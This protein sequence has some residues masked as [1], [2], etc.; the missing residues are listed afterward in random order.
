MARIPT[1]ESQQTRV[2]PKQEFHTDTT[3][4]VV[5][6]S[7]GQGIQ[8]GTQLAGAVENY[9][10]S[11]AEYD[12]QMNEAPRMEAI[13]GGQEKLNVENNKIRA[14]MAKAPNPQRANDLL[15]QKYKELI[16]NPPQDLDD[17][18]L[19]EWQKYMMAEKYRLR[20]NNISWGEKAAKIAGEQA[21]KKANANAFDRMSDDA[22]R[23][24]MERRPFN[25][26]TLDI[27][28]TGRKTDRHIPAVN[29]GD[30]GIQDALTAQHFM[31][32]AEVPLETDPTDQ[33]IKGI[34]G[35]SL[36]DVGATTEGLL[37]DKKAK[38]KQE[39]GNEQI[40]QYFDNLRSAIDDS[41]L[42]D[43]EK[44]VLTDY[45]DAKQKEKRRQFNDYI[46]ATNLETQA[47]LGRVPDPSFVSTYFTNLE[48]QQKEQRENPDE[49]ELNPIRSNKTI[50]ELKSDDYLANL[51]F[52]N[53]YES[54]ATRYSNLP[55]GEV[56]DFSD[57]LKTAIATLSL[58]IGEWDKDELIQK[59][60]PNGTVNELQ[61]LETLAQ[62]SPNLTITGVDSLSQDSGFNEFEWA[63]DQMSE[64]A[65]M[66]TNTNEDKQR[67]QAAINHALYQARKEINRGAGFT[68]PELS[69]L[70]N[71][72]MIG[73][74]QADDGTVSY[75][76][77]VDDDQVIA[78]MQKAGKLIGN[79]NNSSFF[80]KKA[81]SI[82]GGGLRKANAQYRQNKDL[83]QYKAEIRKINQ[84]VLAEK[85]R[86]SIDI[87]DLQNKLENNKSALFVYNGKPYEY[88][89]FSGDKVFVKNGNMKTTLGA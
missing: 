8:A 42:G 66:P 49:L 86:G 51:T 19:K 12:Y 74:Q 55:M 54:V 78:Q 41:G 62:N 30:K 53:D 45:A 11:K 72:A 57:E 68:N 40:D 18:S 50:D 65:S 48:A 20:D 73:I 26:G 88:L 83:E 59:Y 21:A 89:G 7:I 23:A 32:Q 29:S 52:G 85:Y 77:L 27:D 39:I 82:I 10:N 6:N 63:I 5:V 33:A 60:A 3:A 31:G 76:P 84:N 44:N 36:D 47:D 25:A 34:L 75:S 24:G 61:A 22:R 35:D 9:R 64:I 4:S 46:Q 69:A 43:K 67:K 15:E 87:D 17:K 1:Y 37:A 71:D 81:V 58:P 80:N 70:F 56:S 16:N 28:D 2:V 14:D 38:T 79:I 13:Y